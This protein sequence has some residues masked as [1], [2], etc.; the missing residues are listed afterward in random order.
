[1]VSRR[2]ISAIAA[3]SFALPLYANVVVTT[4]VAL[5]S[6]TIT[7]TLPDGDSGSVS[8][9]TGNTV[10]AYAF[11][12]DSLGDVNF[13][14]N[15][16]IDGSITAT[17]PI[18]LATASSAANSTNPNALTASA[19]TGVS[20]PITANVLPG[21][22]ESYGFITA[23]LEI[24]D[25]TDPAP[26]PI[27]VLFTANLALNQSLFTDAYG[28]S[29]DS[30]NQFGIS[31]YPATSTTAPT[32]GMNFLFYDNLLSVGPGTTQ[33]FSSASTPVSQTATL[34]TNTLYTLYIEA[35][36]ESDGANATPEPDTLFLAALAVPVLAVRRILYRRLK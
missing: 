26:V 4:S 33:S 14:D 30:E 19:T 13:Q 15:F 18:P 10:E 22:L 28:I 8:I 21:G 12:S 31:L 11:S 9:P 25:T 35:D 7:P 36:S 5:N 27:S 23:S 20:I 1:M 34:A 2:V 16:N 17:A 3:V 32:P 6:L 24:V 29:A